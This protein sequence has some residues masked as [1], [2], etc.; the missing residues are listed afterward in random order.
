MIL[1]I[2]KREFADMLRKMVALTLIVIGFLW[3]S[4]II[5]QWTVSLGRVWVFR[6]DYYLGHI[7]RG[8]VLHHRVWLFN[9]SFQSVHLQLETSCGCTVVTEKNSRLTELTLQPFRWQKLTIRI[10]TT[11]LSLGNQQQAVWLKFPADSRA[12]VLQPIWVR[13]YLEKP[14]V[15]LPDWFPKLPE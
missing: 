8:T 13:F 9:P 15:Q 12:P 1:I 3:L 6:G 4:A 5:F 10:E 2:W 7:Q 11:G 14:K